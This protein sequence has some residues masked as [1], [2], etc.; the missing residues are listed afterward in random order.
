MEHEGGYEV[1]D[2]VE[3]SGTSG[4]VEHSAPASKCSA[5]PSTS[6]RSTWG[7]GAT[8]TRFRSSVTGIS[9]LVWSRLARNALPLQ[10]ARASRGTEPSRPAAVKRMS[11][12]E[13]FFQGRGR[14]EAEVG[15]GEAGGV[16][17]RAVGEL[18]RD[19]DA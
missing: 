3:V 1:E 9:P 16:P 18:R 2:V 15:G 17:F 4:Q 10:R 5:R 8:M 13:D 12:R 14:P 7:R 19:V 6:Q 11:V